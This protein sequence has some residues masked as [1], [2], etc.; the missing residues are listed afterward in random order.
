MA[1]GSCSTALHTELGISVPETVHLQAS[2]IEAETLHW[3]RMMG[4]T[5][6][7]RDAERLGRA[8]FHLAAARFLPHVPAADVTLFSQW[9]TW[10]FFLD[11]EQ[12]DGL[13]GHDQAWVRRTYG[14][15]L[16]IV[17]TS[18]PP[19]PASPLQAALADLWQRTA[20]RMTP[21]WRTRFTTQM[22]HHRDAFLEQAD[23]RVNG[24]VPSVEDYPRLRRR[25]NGEHMFNLFEVAHRAEI[26]APLARTSAWSELCAAANDITAWCNDIAS[27]DRESASGDTTNYV[28]VFRHALGCDTR[29]AVEQVKQQ[30]RRRLD[31]LRNA[32][33]L[34]GQETHRL[35]LDDQRHPIAQVADT[36]TDLPGTHFGWLLDSGRYTFPPPLNHDGTTGRAEDRPPPQPA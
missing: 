21:A 32:R 19:G 26:P 1:S 25:A 8:R 20:P 13:A 15:L 24:R 17:S 2:D 36:L 6:N 14:S 16:A 29:T 30:I 9:T 4:L 10:F 23:N 7:R 31:D 27:Y 28:T 34:L 11:D 35:H 12:D 5:A 18:R 33:R 22:R 3:A